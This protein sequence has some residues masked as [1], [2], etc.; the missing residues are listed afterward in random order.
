M[1]GRRPWE[2]GAMNMLRLIPAALIALMPQTAGAEAVF[3]PP[4]GLRVAAYR[5]PVPD[6]VPGGRVVGADEVAA[7]AAGGALLIDAMAAPGHAL[8]PKT[9]GSS[10]NRTGPSPRPLAARD[11]AR[12][13]GP[14]DRGGAARLA[15]GLRP[16]AACGPVLQDRLLDE[17]ECSAAPGGSG[18]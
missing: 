4:T 8:T 12:P 9:H 18:P 13:P 17:L 2:A 14:A 15:C 6:S 11:R 10:P 16:G 5:A 1:A 3:D 7:M